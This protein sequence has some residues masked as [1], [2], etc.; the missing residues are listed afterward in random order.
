MVKF[1]YTYKPIVLQEASLIIRKSI[2]ML[3]NDY[4]ILCENEELVC[5]EE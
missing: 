3:D 1:S 5:E 4:E 2:S